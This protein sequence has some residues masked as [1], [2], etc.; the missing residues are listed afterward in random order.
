VIIWLSGGILI[1]VF[2]FA[3]GKW[4]VILDVVLF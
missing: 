4:V 2:K 1:N 3:V